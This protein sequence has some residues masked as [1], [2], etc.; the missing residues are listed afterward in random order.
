MS[1]SFEILG[2][3]E[4]ENEDEVEVPKIDRKE[5]ENPK[6]EPRARRNDPGKEDIIY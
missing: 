2:T 1:N 6:E 3:I 5:V 4:N